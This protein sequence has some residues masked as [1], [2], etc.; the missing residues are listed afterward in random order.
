MYMCMCV[1]VCVCVCVYI[2]VYASIIMY[3][4]SVYILQKCL[5]SE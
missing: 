1:C 2:Y 4:L 5:N 3:V